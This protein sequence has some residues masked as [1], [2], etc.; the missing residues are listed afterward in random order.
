M[1]CPQLNYVWKMGFCTNKI[2]TQLF[3]ILYSQF[4]VV[5]AQWLSEVCTSL[6][7]L[8]ETKVFEKEGMARK[9]QLVCCL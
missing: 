4:E 1:N 5:S 2:W 6:A 8:I 9:F 3:E 7:F